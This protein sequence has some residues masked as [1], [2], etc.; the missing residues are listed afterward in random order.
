MKR[1]WHIASLCAVLGSGAWVH[2]AHGERVTFGIGL[3][4]EI[5]RVLEEVETESAKQAR[6]KS[7]LAALDAR[8]S[9]L[10]DSVKTRVRALYRITR[11]GMT[12]VAGGFEAIRQHVAR[13]RRL[14]ALV[15]NDARAL[16]EAQARGTAA[17]AENALAILDA[18]VAPRPLASAAERQYR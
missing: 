17:Q 14:R 9:Q 5:A 1:S 12:P 15:M 3:D 2:S 6:L 18:S 4:V 13:V 7:E 8:R 11:S 16:H 10:H